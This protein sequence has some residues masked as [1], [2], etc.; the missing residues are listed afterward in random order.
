MRRDPA[1]HRQAVP[2]HYMQHGYIVFYKNNELYLEF[3]LS[4]G[5][6]SKASEKFASSVMEW[7]YVAK[8]DLL[9]P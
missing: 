1:G 6:K 8:S 4:C 9:L 7:L 5:L 3:P 2:I